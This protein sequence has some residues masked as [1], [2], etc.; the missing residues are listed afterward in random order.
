VATTRIIPK[1][2]KVKLEFM[3]GV[4]LGDIVFA[5]FCIGIFLL[6]IFSNLPYVLYLALIWLSIS[7]A[8]FANVEDGVKAYTTIGLAFRFLAYQKKYSKTLKK[9][10]YVDISKIV[11]FLGI[12]DNKFI[13]YKD[14]IAGVIEVM[15]IQYFLLDDYKQDLVI[16]NVTNALRYITQGQSASIVK[17]TKAMLF[18]NYI[19]NEEKKYNAVAKLYRLGE[20]TREELDARENVFNGRVKLLTAINDMP[21][22][23]VYRDCYYIVVYDTDDMQL[24]NTL[25]GMMASLGSGTTQIASKILEGKDLV[26]FLRA[27]YGKNF[28]EREIDKVEP[29]DYL[30]W[31]SPDEIKFKSMSTVIDNVQYSNFVVTDYPLQVSNAWAYEVFSLPKTKVVL[32]ISPTATDR[33]EKNIDNAIMET[34]TKLMH[35]GKSSEVIELQTHLETLQELMIK[36]KN[37]NEQLFDV[38]MHLTCETEVKKQVRSKLRENGFRYSELFGRQVDSFVSSSISKLDLLTKFT[39][40][41]HSSSIA[42]AFPFISSNIMDEKGLYIGDTYDGPT[43]VDFFL[44]DYQHFNSNMIVMGK[45]GSGKSYATKALLA[46]L[47]ADDTKIFVLDPEYEYAQLTDKLKGKLI[48]VGSGLEGRFNPFHVMETLADED[49]E[50]QSNSFMAHLLFLEEYFKVVLEGLTPNALEALNNIVKRKLYKMKN[51]DENT[52]ISKLKPE[53]FPTFDDLYDLSVEELENAKDEFAIE[54]FRLITTYL[55]KFA[56]GGRNSFLWNGPTSIVTDENFVCFNFRSLLANR[57]TVVAAAQMLLVFR[58]LDNEI[59]RNADYNKKYKANRKIVVVV[60]EAHVFINPKHPIALDFMFNMAKRIRKYGGMQVIITQNVKDFVGS[61][62]IARQSAAVI[63]ASHYSMIFSLAPNDLNDLAE[64]YRQSG[65]LNEGERRSIAGAR[66]GQCFFISG[67][68][69][70]TNVQIVALPE[71][72]DMFM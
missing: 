55:D 6:I 47:A 22:N 3:R 62:D 52:H 48:D 2:T 10:G 39:R 5:L 18:D 33:A 8:M 24:M 15:P 66:V 40:G 30:K 60:D 56:H 26:S 19:Y 61:P 67:F 38:N 59:I 9:G 57:N 23:K 65:G 20:I 70:R 32:N 34:Q 29:K 54:N 28:N 72:K 31:I 37:H 49:E 36:L 42:A 43:F 44:R 17:L 71:V 35:A 63:N 68:L 69:A 46:N 12:I 50:S 21:E 7:A 51:I 53:D 64:L 16:D 13:D 4:S 58:Y 25:N 45:S 11:P 14:Y 1:K 41:I 27:N